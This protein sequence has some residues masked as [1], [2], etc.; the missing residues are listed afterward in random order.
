M[1]HDPRKWQV[2][3]FWNRDF[4][5]WSVRQSDGWLC[6]FDVW[7]KKVYAGPLRFLCFFMI[8][9]E[10]ENPWFSLK[11]CSIFYRYPFGKVS[12]SGQYRLNSYMQE[13]SWKN[14]KIATVQHRLFFFIH[15]SNIINR[16]IAPPIT[17]KNRDFKKFRFLASARAPGRSLDHETLTTG[18]LNLL[19]TPTVTVVDP[20]G[21]GEGLVL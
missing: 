20:R 3:I 7:R 13:K 18:T 19:G 12:Q 1:F 2:E 14:T 9:Q 16:L 5:K 6:Y 17:L 21:S 11:S 15:Q 10:F 8:F 4:S